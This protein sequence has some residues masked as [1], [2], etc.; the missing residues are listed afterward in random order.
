LN[1]AEK[2]SNEA[3]EPGHSIK[4]VAQRTGLSSHVIRVWERRYQAITPRRTPTNRRLYSE[5]DIERLRLLANAT[6]AGHTISNVAN[7]S[8]P[9]LQRLLLADQ[10]S[11]RILKPGEAGSPGVHLD[12]AIEA[13]SALD[14]ESLQQVIEHAAVDLPQLTLL[15]EV[16]VPLMI[17]IGE[18]W[19]DNELRIIHEHAAYAVVSAFVSS[20]KTAYSPSSGAP[21]V[22][23]ATPAGQLHELGALIIAATAAADG[24]RTSYLGSS[25]P[26]EE[27]A[28]AVDH[29]GAPAV[30]LSI[31]Y[32]ADDAALPG[33]LLKLRRL[34]PEKVAI[35]A[36]GR[37]AGNYGPVLQEIGARTV[38][39]LQDVREQLADIRTTLH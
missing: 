32:P 8:T 9:E 25:L 16:F 31:V 35:L 19:H 33:E 27:I 34:L 4:I 22:V 36:G 24:W 29:H 20:I 37:S 28:K 21:T 18:L 5:S 39:D 26:A 6:G 1:T 15:E 17:R 3:T 7:L 14:A 30:T 10:P 13:A 23:V 2:N 38:T 11:R 12:R